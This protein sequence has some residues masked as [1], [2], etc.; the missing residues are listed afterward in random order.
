MY[1]WEQIQ[2]TVDYIEAHL[3]ENLTMETLAKQAA[4]SPFY[5][6]RLF[7]RLVKKPVME[8]IRL[9]RMAVAAE[10][11]LQQ[12]KRILDIAVDLGFSSTSTSPAP[13]RT[14]SG[15]RPRN[16]AGIRLR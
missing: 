9:R 8:Y 16:I 15:S 3:N 7:G 4:L 12:D 1:A 2:K 11:L 5:F 6:Q 10:T 14:P 13:S